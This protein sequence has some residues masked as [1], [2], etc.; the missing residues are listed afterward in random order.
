MQSQ[1]HSFSRTRE[2]GRE[3]DSR[4]SAA[5][6]AAFALGFWEGVQGGARK[7]PRCLAKLSRTHHSWMWDL[8]AQCQG[9]WG[10][11]HRIQRVQLRQRV[12]WSD[13]P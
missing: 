6:G 10:K 12:V 3:G 13:T 9:Q 2:G 4:D 8:W 5:S 11:P 1:E 7:I